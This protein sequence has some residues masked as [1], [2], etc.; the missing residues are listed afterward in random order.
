MPAENYWYRRHLVVYEWIGARVIGQRVLDMACGEG[1]GSEVLSRSARSVVGVDAN[2]EAHEHARLRYA[3]QNLR[4]ERGLVETYGEPGASTRSCSCRRSSTSRTPCAVLEHFRSLL[5]PG[6]DGVRLDARTC[7]RSRRRAPSKSRQPVARARVPGRRVPRAVRHARSARSSCSAC[8]TPASSRC[9][10][11]RST[12]GW[13][14]VHKRLRLTKPFYDRFTPAIATSDFALRADELD[15]RARLPRGMPGVSPG[16]REQGELAIVLHTHMPYVE[17]FGTW[18]FGEEWLWEA[19]ATLLR[20]AA[21]RA[22]RGAPITLSLTPVLCDQLEAPGVA[23]RC[24]A[25]L[26][27]IRP[28]SHG[29]TSS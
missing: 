14:A 13:D 3:R 17:G 12:L 24:L 2:P 4:F 21:R 18:P 25:F 5:A 10:S 20:A 23:E 11:G 27:E 8:S 26:R 29:A 15:A 1:Y 6:G 28:E 22:R 9:T 19:I 16:A 7:S